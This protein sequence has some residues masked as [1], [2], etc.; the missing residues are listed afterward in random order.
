MLVYGIV[1]NSLSDYNSVD[2]AQLMLVLYR[3]IGAAAACLLI[4]GNQWT[5]IHLDCDLESTCIDDLVLPQS[6]LEI[7][8]LVMHPKF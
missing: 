7:S 1:G 2:L 6:A 8:I 5:I 4:G 3:R